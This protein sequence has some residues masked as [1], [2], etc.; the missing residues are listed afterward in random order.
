MKNTFARGLILLIAIIAVVVVMSMFVGGNLTA[1]KGDMKDIS[2]REFLNKVT[3]NGVKIVNI[4]EGESMLVGLKSDTKVGD[5]EFPRSYD[6]KT[7]LP[8]D[9]EKDIN[10]I[11]AARTGKKVDEITKNDW[12]FELKYLP[13]PKES[14]VMMVLPYLITLAIIGGMWFLFMRQMQGNTNKAMSF[15]KSR[16]TMVEG[17]QRTVTFVDVAGADE[18][19]EELAEIVEFLKNPQKFM[20]LGARI[21]KGVLL[22]GPP[23]TGKTLLARAV[24]GEAGVPFFTISGSDFVELYVGVGASRVRDLFERAKRNTPCIVFIDEIDAV[25]RH[26]GAGMGGGH[27]E[28]EQTLN[29]LL[30]EMDGFNINE[31]IIILA[32]TNR[33]D[34]LDP[35]LLRPGRFDRQV[36]VSYPDV[37]GREAVLKVHSRGKPLAPDTNLEVVAKMTPMFTGADLENVMNEAAILAARRNRKTITMAEITEAINRVAMGPEKK[38]RKVTELD[39]KLVACHEAGHALVAYLVPGTDPVQEVSIIPRGMAGGY[40]QM[41]PNEEFHYRTKAKLMGDIA[42]SMGGHVAERVLLGDITTGSTGDLKHASDLARRMITEYG[43][44]DEL[45]P[46]YL[47]E[48]KE[49]FVGASF[50]RTREYSEQLSA[51]IDAEIHKL[52]DSAER[53]ATEII[54]GNLDRL[55]KIIDRLLEKEK[56]SGE[57]F[58]DLMKDEPEMA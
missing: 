49:I 42:V 40:T 55:Q 24:S 47:A 29:Q 5:K 35:A 46:V 6:F 15:G 10:G 16:A 31:G 18:E 36:T 21:P 54:S 51:K 58:A 28:R 30:V 9:Y 53:R 27:D 52:L 3:E 56:I 44:S 37:K 8:K 23:G 1:G 26:R 57:E 38:S 22:V 4:V 43:M 41:L 12:T 19:K 20:E 17:N 34:I 50:G 2:Y 48:D 25:G 11:Y 7:Q 32:A 14:W 45:G 39:R 13:L 33:P